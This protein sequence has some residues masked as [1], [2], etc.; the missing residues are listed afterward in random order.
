ML[1]IMELEHIPSS[2]SLVLIGTHFKSG[3]TFA[4]SRVKQAEALIQF[5]IENYSNHSHIIVVADFNGT[6]NERFYS[7]LWNYGFRSSYRTLMNDH[8][9]DFTTWKFTSRNYINKEEC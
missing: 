2:I 9:P 6:M 8:E 5:L 1:A 4:D 7:K 3:T